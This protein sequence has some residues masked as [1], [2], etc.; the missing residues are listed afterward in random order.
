MDMDDRYYIVGV[1]NDEKLSWNNIL[2]I[3]RHPANGGL[4]KVHTKSGRTTTAT[5][6]HSFLKRTENGIEPITGDELEIGH[7]V[8]IANFIPKFENIDLED[9]QLQRLGENDIYWDVITQLE[10]LDDPEDYVYDFTVPGNDS[11]MINDGMLVHNTL[12]TFHSAGI[13]S[14]VSLG[15]PRAK[16]I[17]SLSTKLKTPAMIIPLLPEYKQN[18][19][20]TNRIVSN[21]KY[22]TLKDVRKG[23]KIFYD[24][25]PLEKGGFMDKDRIKNVFFSQTQ[26]KNS[27]QSDISSLPWLVRIKMDREKMMEKDVTLLDIKSMYCNAWERRNIDS[28]G[29]KKEEKVLFEAITQTSILSNTENDSK[30]IIHIRFD[31][32]SYNYSTFESFIDVFIDSFKLKGISSVT[33]IDNVSE[34]SMV[35]F[36]NEDQT[37]STIKHN[38]IYTIGSNLIDIRY[39]NGIDLNNVISNN[40]MEIYEL[41]GIDACRAALIREFKTVFGGAGS[42]VN[43]VHIELLCDSM[44]ISGI[45]TSIDR[46]GMDKTDAE[47]LARATF[48]KTV[49]KLLT[50]AMFSEIDHMRSVSSRIMT[51][52][53]FGGGTC[54]CE[55]LLDTEMLQNTE[56]TEEI[57]TKRDKNYREITTSSVIDDVINRDVTGI[58]IP[59]E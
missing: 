13:K 39:L 43:Y 5:L 36:D 4:V 58:F 2:Q 26:N 46:H 20:V 21:L 24:P 16:E 40:I 10:Y 51:G 50:A 14:S 28:K 38:V 19:D 11:F 29:M 53:P 59:D 45:P 37:L 52:L 23:I 33:K 34:E 1:S 12:K 15:V 3:S 42:N 25:T 17:L 22:T 35:S 55:L 7:T 49:E 56:V 48:E 9:C 8:P 57:V 44:T 18:M 47:P 6:S 31:M 30:P 54:A 27:C 41:Y 32:N